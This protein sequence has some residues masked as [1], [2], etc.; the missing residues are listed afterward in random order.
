M[1]ASHAIFK[2]NLE[3][4]ETLEKLN[5]RG[6]TLIVVTHDKNVGARSIR[7]LEMVDGRIQSDRRR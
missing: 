3:V 6:I 1:R 7:S 2:R 5:S 4:I